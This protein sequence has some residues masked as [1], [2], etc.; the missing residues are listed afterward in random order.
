[1]KDPRKAQFLRPT[2]DEGTNWILSVRSLPQTLHGAAIVAAYI[3][4]PAT[5]AV[6]MEC[7]T[8]YRIPSNFWDSDFADG[9]GKSLRGPDD[10][11]HL[12]TLAL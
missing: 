5:M 9:F 12:I 3:D 11:S 4:P 2:G 10:L 1:M 7:F 6:A 8:V